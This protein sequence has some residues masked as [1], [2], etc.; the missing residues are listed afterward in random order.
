MMVGKYEEPFSIYQNLFDKLW[1]EDVLMK[2]KIAK[3]HGRCF[4]KSMDKSLE[5]L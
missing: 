3:N 2:L 4:S 5:G 1:P